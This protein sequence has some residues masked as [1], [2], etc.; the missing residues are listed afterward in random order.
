MFVRSDVIADKSSTHGIVFDAKGQY[1]TRKEVPEGMI[2]DERKMIFVKAS[3]QRNRG[4]STPPVPTSL[5]S[6]GSFSSPISSPTNASDMSSSP[7][8]IALPRS[9]SMKNMAKTRSAY[10]GRL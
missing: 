10:L 7:N 6:S 1:F 8:T 5:S 9:A 3:N 2:Y 4:N